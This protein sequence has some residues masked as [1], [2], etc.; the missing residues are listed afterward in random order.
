MPVVAVNAEDV[1]RWLVTSKRAPAA[2][3]DDALGERRPT[4]AFA[5]GCGSFRRNAAATN[6]LKHA[7]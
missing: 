2:D 4:A 5:G 6:G 1:S 3:N 7:R